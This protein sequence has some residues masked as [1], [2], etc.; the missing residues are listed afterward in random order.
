MIRDLKAL[1][2]STAAVDELILVQSLLKT[3]DEGYQANRADTPEW[4][5]N[6]LS[7]VNA[8]IK[9]N[10]RAIL[11]A[12]LRQAKSRRDA[13]A[14]PDEKRSKV[15]DEIKALEAKLAE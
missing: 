5:T 8:K 1:D 3:L 12:K 7:G 6:Q 4:V 10:F 15:D 13:L 14:T 2:P 9:D 11:E